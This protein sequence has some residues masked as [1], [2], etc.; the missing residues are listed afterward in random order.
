MNIAKFSRNLFWKISVNG[1]CFD[2]V[3]FTIRVP[4]TSYASAT[5]VPDTSDASA[6]QV[7]HECNTSATQ[8][9]R[10]CYTNDTSAIRVRYF[11]FDSD[12]SE[13]IL[14]IW[15]MKIYKVEQFHSQNCLLEMPRSHAKMHLNHKNWT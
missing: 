14:A 1:G 12:A 8:V 3:Y 2:L 10:E 5:Q 4:D 15:R 13:N 9:R 11:D 7:W 6:T